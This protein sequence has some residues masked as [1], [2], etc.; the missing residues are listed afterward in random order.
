MVENTAGPSYI[1]SGDSDSEMEL[2][3]PSPDSFPDD[4]VIEPDQSLPYMWGDDPGMTL[5]MLFGEHD[6]SEDSHLVGNTACPSNIPSGDSDS[7]S[8]DEIRPGIDIPSEPRTTRA[9]RKI[10][11]QSVHYG[12]L[13]TDSSCLG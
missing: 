9:G 11:L 6:L 4:G 12:A 1:P 8:G 10:Q 3:M 13:E 2:E 5:P 7:D